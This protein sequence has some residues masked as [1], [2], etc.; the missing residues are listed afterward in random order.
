MGVPEGQREALGAIDTGPVRLHLHEGHV[1]VY[2][3]YR[4]CQWDMIPVPTGMGFVW[5]YL[6]IA[7]AEIASAARMLG[8]KR[9]RLPTVFRLVREMASA[10][11]PVLNGAKS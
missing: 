10:A 7:A 11:A 9:K 2:E 8:I 4:S 3:V 1:D 5:Q 6:G